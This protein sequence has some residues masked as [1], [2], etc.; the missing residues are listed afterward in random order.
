MPVCVPFLSSN[1]IVVCLIF[2]ILFFRQQKQV[3]SLPHGHSDV[4]SANNVVKWHWNWFISKTSVLKILQLF[5]RRL[6]STRV[7]FDM[8]DLVE[9]AFSYKSVENYENKAK[10]MEYIVNSVDQYANDPRRSHPSD[11]FARKLKH[12]LK[13]LFLCS[14][15]NYLGSRLV[16]SYIF[17]KLLYLLNSCAQFF[18]VNEFLGKQLYDLGVDFVR[19]LTNAYDV[20]AVSD[21]IYFPKVVLC[22]FKIREF[23]NLNCE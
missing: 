9:A 14:S 23:G 6:L 7:G 11:S 13:S 22:D 8:H 19:Y 2:F 20:E 10:V 16:T 18:L 3:H 12:F 17:V 21:S 1:C 4:F 15:G 5:A